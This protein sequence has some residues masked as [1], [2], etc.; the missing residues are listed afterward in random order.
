MDPIEWWIQFGGDAPHLRKV[1][2]PVL[3]Q[4]TTS[5]GCERN[6]S[7]FILIHTKVRNR[8]SY[9][10][11]EK[12]VYVYYNMWL[13]LRCAELDKNELEELDVEPIDLQ[14]Y[15]EDSEAML[16]WVEATENQEDPLLDEAGDSQRP[17]CFIIE[18]IEEEAHL[19]QVEDPPQSE[20]GRSSH[21]T[22]ETQLSQSSA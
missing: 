7:T 19:Q 17:S 13:K 18:T 10:R 14:L 20:H 21:S 16:E 9:K 2:I 6:W 11:L 5:S 8:L 22:S 15:N 12:L 1:V 3:S 4:T